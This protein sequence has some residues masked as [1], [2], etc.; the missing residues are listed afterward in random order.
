MTKTIPRDRRKLI[1]LVLRKYMVLGS[2]THLIG[3]FIKRHLV[4]IGE[5]STFWRSG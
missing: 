5:N 1:I 3:K 2:H 4:M